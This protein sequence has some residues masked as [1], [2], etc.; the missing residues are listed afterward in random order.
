MLVH[1]V[2]PFETNKTMCGI[3][4]L[5]I[6]KDEKVVPIHKWDMATNRCEDCEEAFDDSFIM[7]GK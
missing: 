6:K 4:L 5:N 7:E 1:L 2:K 3:P